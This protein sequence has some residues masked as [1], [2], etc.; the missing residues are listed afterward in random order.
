[1]PNTDKTAVE[2]EWA[3]DTPKRLEERRM[4]NYSHK[5][6]IGLCEKQNESS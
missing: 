3:L 4:T 2:I 1:M 5:R 6:I